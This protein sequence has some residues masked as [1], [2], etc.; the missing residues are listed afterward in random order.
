MTEVTYWWQVTERSCSCC[1]A[2]S[3]CWQLRWG[4]CSY[5]YCARTPA[6][7]H[8]EPKTVNNFCQNWSACWISSAFSVWLEHLIKAGCF[9]YHMEGNLLWWA[10][11]DTFIYESVE[12]ALADVGRNF[13]PELSGDD[14]APHWSA[15]KKR[16]LTI[17]HIL[18]IKQRLLSPPLTVNRWGNSW[19]V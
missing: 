3:G 4:R 17:N 6:F 18:Q 8:Q 1:G 5:C 16:T 14:R 10:K 19:N 2:S 11:F 12:V 7:P 15:L 9:S 13:G